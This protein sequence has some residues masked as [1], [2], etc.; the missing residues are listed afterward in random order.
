MRVAIALL[1]PVL[2]VAQPSQPEQLFKTAVEAHNRGDL[3]TAV[4]NYRK[5]LELRPDIIDAR[6]NLGAALARLGRFDAAVAEYRKVLQQEPANR[7]VRLNLAL[8]LYKKRDFPAA[9]VELEALRKTDS[10]NL[11]IG[12]LLA[13]SY[14]QLE[15]YSDAIAILDPLEAA[16]PANPDIAF[17]LGSA[18]IRIGRDSDGLPRVER[19]AESTKNPA[20]FM[21]AGE[22]YLARQQY[23]H[24]KRNIE[25]AIKLN[26]ELP[27]LRTLHGIVLEKTGD[28]AQAAQIFEKVLAASP[29]DFQAHLHLGAILFRQRDLPAARTHLTRALELNPSSPL[30]QYEMGVLEKASGNLDAAA[31]YLESV[32]KQSP[33]WVQPHIEL[34]ALYYRLKRPAD[35]ARERAIVD[36]LNAAKDAED[37]KALE[38]TS[39]AP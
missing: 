34:A 22:T 19:V 21:L 3:E 29:G 38:S 36:R 14:L 16:H 10:A 24:A 32:A 4:S 5:L 23:D 35:G 18:L 17:I 26:A 8:A 9:A 6:G 31:A 12:A 20:A 1:F 37:R 13:D 15:R 11:Q 25:T 39:S 7:A 2:V 30:A 27:G 33:D 28:H